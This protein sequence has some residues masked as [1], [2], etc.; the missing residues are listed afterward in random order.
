LNQTPFDVDDVSVEGFLDYNYRVFG[1][2][3]L[4]N[5]VSSER[6]DSRKTHSKWHSLPH[7]KT[8]SK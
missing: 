3:S 5:A 2:Y 8:H 4:D 6:I 7:L 1:L